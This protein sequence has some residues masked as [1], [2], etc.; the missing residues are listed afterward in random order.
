M[1]FGVSSENIDEM[2]TGGS[3]YS[4]APQLSAS[5]LSLLSD[6]L[7]SSGGKMP[8]LSDLPLKKIRKEAG[9]RVEKAVIGYVLDKTGWNRS[10][11]SRILDVSYRSLLDK[12]QELEVSSPALFQ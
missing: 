10:K 2:L 8:E 9:N 7:N 12:I 1:V 6:Y 5:T 3:N 11:A 4:A